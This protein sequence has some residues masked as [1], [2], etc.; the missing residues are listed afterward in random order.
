MINQ[1]LKTKNLT[2]MQCTS[3]YP[4]PVNKI[5]LNVLNKFKKYNCVLG[6]SDHSLGIEASIAAVSIGAE[7]IEK[8]LTLDK[9]MKGPDHSSSI[10]PK[11]FELMVKSIRSLENNL[12]N[13]ADP[14]IVETKDGK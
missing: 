11:E 12:G 2:L 1:K 5:G 8:H 14:S 3:E 6:L 10:E 9:R 7:I 4:C 13:I